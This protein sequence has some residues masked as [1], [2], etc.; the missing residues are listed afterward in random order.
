MLTRGRKLSIV[1]NLLDSFD[2]PYI[3]EYKT[4]WNFIIGKLGVTLKLEKIEDRSLIYHP[5][6]PENE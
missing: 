3:P 5:C 2:V 1:H 6:H 4:Q